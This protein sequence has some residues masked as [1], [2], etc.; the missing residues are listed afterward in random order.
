MPISKKQRALEWTLADRTLLLRCLVDGLATW[1][2]ATNQICV[3]GIGYCTGKDQNG[4]PVLHDHIRSALKQ[5]DFR[6][7]SP[8]PTAGAYRHG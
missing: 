3:G 7:A 5:A 6:G 4:I 2:P 8:D 1:E